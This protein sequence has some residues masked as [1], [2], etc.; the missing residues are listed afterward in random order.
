MADYLTR[1]LPELDI[2]MAVEQENTG[3]VQEYG[4]CGI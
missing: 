3:A 2:D 1:M 4:R